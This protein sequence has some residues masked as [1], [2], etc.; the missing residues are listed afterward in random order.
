[1]LLNFSDRTRTGVFNMV[2]PL[3][4]EAVKL[5]ILEMQSWQCWVR[6]GFL[7]K[8]FSACGIQTRPLAACWANFVQKFFHLYDLYTGEPNSYYP[9]GREAE[10]EK[11]ESARNGWDTGVSLPWASKLDRLRPLELNF[12]Q[13]I[14][15]IPT[16]IL[17]APFSYYP[18]ELQM[19]KSKGKR[20]KVTTAP[21][22]PRRSPI[23]VLTGPNVA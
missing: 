2:W 6:L 13:K 9:R 21:S 11:R 19:D 16:F 5:A 23:Q 10:R 14:S 22:V 18:R 12:F 20:A 8:G 17:G 3:P 1:M 7:N 15:T 4:R